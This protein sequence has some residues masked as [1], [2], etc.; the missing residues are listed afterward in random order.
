MRAFVKHFLDWWLF[1][2][3]GSCVRE[4]K[5]NIGMAYEINVLTMALFINDSK[6]A[7]SIADNHTTTRLSTQING[8]GE[9]MLDA[10]RP[11]GFGYATG[12]FMGLMDLARVT[13]LAGGSID[14]YT[15]VNASTGATL[16]AVG[17]FFGPFCTATC[18][19]SRL[20]HDAMA[21]CIGW[22]FHQVRGSTVLQLGTVEM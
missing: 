16:R 21:K 5:A 12:D 13:Q 17:D 10:P 3:D 14:L 20:G 2:T 18:N 1:S 19:A 11:D 8:R 7:K 4:T 15:Y 9:P 6:A 22:P